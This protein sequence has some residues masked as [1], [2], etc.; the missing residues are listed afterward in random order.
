MSILPILIG[1]FLFT[2][3]NQDNPLSRFL[4]QIDLSSLLDLL[5]QFG[6]GEHLLSNIP[7]E[8]ITSLLNGEAD[9]K[10]LLPLLIKFFMQKKE[11]VSPP[12]KSFDTDF[13]FINGEIK[14][15]LYNYLHSV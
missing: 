11:E 2:R 9:L 5:K 7:Q 3:N 13:N 4:S 14:T 15:A 8:L 12:Q 6:I 10:T 1:L